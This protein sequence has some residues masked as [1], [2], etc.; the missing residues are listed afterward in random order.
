M[1]E[2]S[3]SINKFFDDATRT[4]INYILDNVIIS[5]HLQKVFTMRYIE[6]KNIDF[7]AYSTGYS[8]S[9]IESDLRKIRKKIYKLI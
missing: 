5:E 1:S 8:K 4:E 6:D 9:K 3:K 7:I 2:I